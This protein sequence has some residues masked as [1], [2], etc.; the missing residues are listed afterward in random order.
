[1]KFQ[2]QLRG[3]ETG[4]LVVCF[5]WKKLH[6]EWWSQP[7]GN[8]KGSD[9]HMEYEYEFMLYVGQRMIL[10]E[11]RYISEYSDN[12][13]EFQNMMNRFNEKD[14]GDVLQKMEY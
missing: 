1:M 6:C 12:K 2:S 4:L 14:F 11:T 5:D 8:R 3:K 9:E 7:T 10:S 13:I